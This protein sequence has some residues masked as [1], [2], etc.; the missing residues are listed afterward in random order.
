MTYDGV[1]WLKPVYSAKRVAPPYALVDVDGKVLQYV[2]PAPGLN[3]SRHVKKPVGMFGQ[4]SHLAEFKADHLTVS[5]V[6]DL[7]K[8]QK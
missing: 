8:Y 2:T 4:K 5:K 1:G 7:T 3:L 6:V